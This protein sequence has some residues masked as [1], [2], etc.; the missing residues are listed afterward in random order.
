[1]RKPKTGRGQDSNNATNKDLLLCA[2]RD[3]IRMLVEKSVINRGLENGK[4]LGHHVHQ[5]VS[6]LQVI[7][8]LTSFKCITCET[9]LVLATAHC[10]WI[11]HRPVLQYYTALLA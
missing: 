9:Q 2:A 5:I 7:T 10:C 11:M 8:P 3:R 6:L 4:G 1:V